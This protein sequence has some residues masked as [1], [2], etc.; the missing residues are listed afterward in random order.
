MSSDKKQSSELTDFAVFVLLFV[1]GGIFLANFMILIGHVAQ[2]GIGD[3]DRA[4]G[5][6]SYVYLLVGS[7][8][9]P[10]LLGSERF[11]YR[12]FGTLLVGIGFVVLALVSYQA[13]DLFAHINDY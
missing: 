10:R 13:I 4:W 8:L 5:I 1:F 6:A 3:D 2:G 11:A 9:S 12:A 7:L